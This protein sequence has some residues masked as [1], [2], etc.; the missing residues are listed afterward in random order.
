MSTP[1]GT[2][3]HRP[4]RGRVSEPADEAD[5]KSAGLT[6]RVGSNPSSPTTFYRVGSDVGRYA[7]PARGHEVRLDGERDPLIADIIP[8]TLFDI[9]K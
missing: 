4:L 2:R 7:L 1:A 3:R 5:L 6:G 9:V 8:E